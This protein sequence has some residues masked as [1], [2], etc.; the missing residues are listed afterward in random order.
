MTT[1]PQLLA[2]YAS[3]VEAAMRDLIPPLSAHPSFYH[4]LH[5]HLGWSDLEGN[6]LSLPGGKRVRAALCLMACETLGGTQAQG[7]PAAAAVELLHEFSL[8]HD[9]IQ[10]QDRAR[11]HRPTL[12]TLVGE[13][14]AINAGDGLFALAQQALLSSTSEGIAAEKVLH[15]QRRFNETA[16]ALCIGQ[17]LDMSFETRAVIAPEEYLEMIR[18]KTA[19]LLAFACEV[20][21]LLAGAE[22]ESIRALHEMGEALGLAFQMRDDL[23]GL[24]GDPEL[25]GKPVGADIRARKKSLPVAYALSQPQSEQLRALYAGPLSESAQIQ[26]ARRLIEATGAR[27]YA[28][29]LAEQQAQRAHEALAHVQAKAEALAPLQQLVTHLTHR[30]Y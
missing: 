16:V 3:A 12:W 18:G 25:T 14:Q 11:R 20:G 28:T 2:P 22:A 7:L 8:I 24:W 17:H 13:A 6:A 21:A 5:Y 19:T 26:E 10:D 27:E 30:D 29:Q 1:L 15:A 23:L 4:Q 9:D